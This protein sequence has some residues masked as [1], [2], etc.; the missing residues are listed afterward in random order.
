MSSGYWDT[1]HLGLWDPDPTLCVVLLILAGTSDHSLSP[2]QGASGTIVLSVLWQVAHR[3]V[4]RQ[5]SWVT[6][7]KVMR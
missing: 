3:M 6:Y 1:S 7:C 2:R 5:Y 4:L